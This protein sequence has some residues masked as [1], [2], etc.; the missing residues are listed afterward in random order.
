MFSLLKNDS[1]HQNNT[2][3]YRIAAPSSF[4]SSL[5][6][7][8]SSCV[9]RNPVLSTWL[10]LPSVFQQAQVLLETSTMASLVEVAFSTQGLCCLCFGW[11]VPRYWNG[12]GERQRQRDTGTIKGGESRNKKESMKER[13]MEAGCSTAIGNH[14]RGSAEN[15][16]VFI[17]TQD[18]TGQFQWLAPF[19][20]LK[21]RSWLNIKLGSRE[22][23][24]GVQWE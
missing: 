4:R 22:Q 5:C 24:Y 2:H 11:N 8:T 10:L 3:S 16:Q 1:F 21:V 18:L 9:S 12:G 15:T 6:P 20:W 14:V 17:L 19:F 23:R 7:E 13:Q